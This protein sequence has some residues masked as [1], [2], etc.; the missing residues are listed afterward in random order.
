[1]L[2]SNEQSSCNG[3]ASGGVQTSC[4]SLYSVYKSAGQCQ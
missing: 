2:A 4:A 1:M 3:V